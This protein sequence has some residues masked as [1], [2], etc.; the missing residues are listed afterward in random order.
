MPLVK[1][2]S[3]T[4]EEYY[5]IFK[6]IYQ[7]YNLFLTCKGCNGEIIYITFIHDVFS[8]LGLNPEELDPEI[9]CFQWPSIKK[10]NACIRSV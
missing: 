6:I 4:I 1:Y 7:R 8:T 10:C 3:V 2:Y 9:F 5:N